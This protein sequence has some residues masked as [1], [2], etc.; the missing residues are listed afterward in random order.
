MKPEREFDS[1][2]SLLR[3]VLPVDAPPNERT[4]RSAPRRASRTTNARTT[5]TRPLSR[6]RDP[7]KSKESD[8]RVF[9][10]ATRAIQIPP[11]V[12]RLVDFHAKKALGHRTDGPDRA[13]A[14]RRSAR[15]SVGANECEFASSFPVV[16]VVGVSRRRFPSSTPTLDRHLARGLD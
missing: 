11:R 8:S 6:P 3:L 14:L 2:G 1:A 5:E 4:T 13:E 10:D 15:R 12:G 9:V 16:V 7:A